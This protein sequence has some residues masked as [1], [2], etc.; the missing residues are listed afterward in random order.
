MQQYGGVAVNKA[1][2]DFIESILSPGSTILEFGS[3]PG[4]TI[5]LSNKYKLYSV[6]IT[7]MV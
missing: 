3:G 4:S 2:V 1:C 6:E 5:A 7:R